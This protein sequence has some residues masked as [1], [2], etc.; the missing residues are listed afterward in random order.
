MTLKS[1]VI[2]EF[3]SFTRV[4]DMENGEKNQI[5]NYDIIITCVKFTGGINN[6][7]YVTEENMNELEDIRTEMIQNES[8]RIKGFFF[9]FTNYRENYWV[10]EQL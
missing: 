3:S 2:S 5:S 10:V 6:I 8:W 1:I 9:F 7:L 4:R